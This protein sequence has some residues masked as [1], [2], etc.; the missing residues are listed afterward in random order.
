MHVLR[1]RKFWASVLSIFVA[2][3]AVSLNDSQQ[4]E[5]VAQIAAGIGAIYTL[6]VALEDGLSNRGLGDVLLPEITI[7][8]DE[9]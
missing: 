8:D 2:I 9:Q 4:A 1:S 7:D 6:A 5:L 3:G